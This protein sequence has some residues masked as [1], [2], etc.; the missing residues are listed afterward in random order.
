MSDTLTFS[1]PELIEARQLEDQI[2]AI[3]R[4][5]HCP[6]PSK[7]KIYYDDEYFTYYSDE[8]GQ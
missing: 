6:D 8:S 5:L 3:T 4:Q 1:S 7:G 2:S